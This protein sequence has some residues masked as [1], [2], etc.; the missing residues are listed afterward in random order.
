MTTTITYTGGTITPAVVNGF[1]S[2]RP[3]R[4]VVHTILGRPDPDITFRP[5]GLQKGVLTLVFAT[6]AQARSAESALTVPRIFT[7]SDI[8]VPEVAMQFVVADGDVSIRLDLET[9][10]VWIVEVPFQEVNP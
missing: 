4:T 3:A 6:G 1:D 10:S 5:A 8:D 9:Q 7:L 2:S